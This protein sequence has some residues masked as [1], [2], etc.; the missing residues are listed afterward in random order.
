[1]AFYDKFIIK[2]GTKVDL[3]DFD[4][5]DTCG[6]TKEEGKARTAK[7][8]ERMKELQEVMYAEHKRSLCAM[9]QAVDA[10]GKDGAVNNNGSVMNI[11]GVQAVSLK[12]PSKRE[13]DQDFLWRVEQVMPQKGNILFLNRTQEEDVL[14]ARVKKL[15]P[16]KVIED[17]YD[18]INDFEKLHMLNGTTFAKFYLLI[19][20]EE[21]WKRFGARAGNPD[22]RWKLA[23]G[24]LKSSNVDLA[25]LAGQLEGLDEKDL[26][27]KVRELIKDAKKNASEYEGGDLMETMFWDAHRKAANIA[28]SRNSKKGRE[29]IVV[30]SNHKWFRDLVVS[31]V[32]RD[33]MEALDMKFP[34]PAANTDKILERHFSGKKWQKLR[35]VFNKARE[36][37]ASEGQK[38]GKSEKP[39]HKRCR[40]SE[41]K[42]KHG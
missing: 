39:E 35:D 13:L 10:A 18:S 19:S 3:D 2:P 8:H 17:R 25:K 1:M 7:N 41:P 40:K 31:Q 24:E 36:E 23:D 4:P 20:Q 5:D 16:K 11:E 12:Q 9:F 33:K 22:K 34:E 14:V 30:P 27:K 26:V 28:L 37:A 32:L 6:W 29:W 15:A 21:Q 38:L 42:Q